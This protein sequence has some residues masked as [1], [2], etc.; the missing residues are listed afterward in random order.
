M[1]Y[2]SLNMPHNHAIDDDAR[3]ALFALAGARHCG[4]SVASGNTPLVLISWWRMIRVTHRKPMPLAACDPKRTAGEQTLLGGNM[5]ITTVR[6]ILIVLFVTLQLSAC[7]SRRQ[8]DSDFY[9]RGQPV[10]PMEVTFG[11]VVFTRKVT[12]GGTTQSNLGGGALSAF[13]AL[14]G[15]A[16][17]APDATRIIA[18]I[19]AG[20]IANPA[21][22]NLE[23]R[24][25]SEDG[26][27]VTVAT[28][29]EPPKY[30]VVVQRNSQKISEKIDLI[31]LESAPIPPTSKPP[32]VP[33]A[34]VSVTRVSES[35]VV[36]TK[37]VKTTAPKAEVTTTTVTE[38]KKSETSGPEAKASETK[39]SVVN[40]R[41][42]SDPNK[43]FK[44]RVV[45]CL[46]K[47]ECDD[48]CALQKKT[49]TPDEPKASSGG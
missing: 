15:L 11:R 4:R 10:S 26:I 35:K 31:D 22:A 1:L 36:E 21:G 28:C 9:D 47:I 37:V 30:V 40:V 49:K 16:L 39:V 32:L 43:K 5:S 25:T 42:L 24:M 46:N 23:E 8:L 20:T 41:V 45:P 33:D 13:G 48:G 19:T 7:A 6:T 44:S 2:T 27:E 3:Q 17:N 38:T 14:A 29:A 18:A 34:T 12:I